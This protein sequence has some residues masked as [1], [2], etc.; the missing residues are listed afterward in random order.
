MKGTL[1]KTVSVLVGIGIGLF[2]L[3]GCGTET[4]SRDHMPALQKI[5]F[6]L[7]EAVV[8]QNR[9]AIDSLLSI[10]I[11]SAGESSD[12]LLSFVYGANGDFSFERFGN[13]QIYYT[14][15]LARID[16]FVMDSLGDTARPIILTLVNQHNLWLLKRF[17]IKEAADSVTLTK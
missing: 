7:Q 16:C 5:L 2:A 13:Y 9:A 14:D 15:E 12:S 10:D 17:D 8:G 6:Q 3:V 11:L 1:T 4:P